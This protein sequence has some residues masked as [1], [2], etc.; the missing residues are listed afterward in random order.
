MCKEPRLMESASG[1]L[2]VKNLKE[3]GTP[4][5]IIEGNGY[6]RFRSELDP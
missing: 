4:V 6:K 2:G 5:E 3:S 1:V